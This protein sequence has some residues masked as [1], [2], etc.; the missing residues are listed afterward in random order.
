MIKNPE[1]RTLGKFLLCGLL[2][3]IFLDQV[4]VESR[5]RNMG[6]QLD[7][8]EQMEPAEIEAPAILMLSDQVGYGI[9]GEPA[10]WIIR[11]MDGLQYGEGVAHSPEERE[12]LRGWVEARGGGRE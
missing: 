12:E 4:R 10:W 6:E 3:W 2:V 8:I 9:D 1:L 11:W 7:A 5:F